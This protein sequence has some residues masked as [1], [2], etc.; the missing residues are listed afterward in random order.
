MPE[1]R[2]RISLVIP[3]YNE[4]RRIGATLERV[5]A[6]FKN[7]DYAYEILVVD[8]GSTD[9]TSEAVQ[10]FVPAVRLIVYS[11][12]R[13]KGYAM[14]RGLEEAQGAYRV[15]YDA[16]ASTP[17]DEI[18]KLWPEFEK[19]ASVI[20]GSRALPGSDVQIRQPNYRRKMGRAYNLLLRA[21]RLTSFRDTQC[22]FKAFTEESCRLILPRLT[23]NG[24]GSDCEM[25]FVAQIHGLSVVQVPIRWI[26]SFDSRVDPLVDSLAM[27]R[28]VLL[29]RLNAFRGRY[30]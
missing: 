7:Q 18:D 15:V 23:V 19:A 6:Y 25:L 11:K 29:I 8:D 22:G 21:L 13:G 9:D 12:N 10:R 26:N 17:I 14:R 27:I 1:P 3:A 5:T 16:D 2:P 24:F 20:I 28:E 30:R 4:G